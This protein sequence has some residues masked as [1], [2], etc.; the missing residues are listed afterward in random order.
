MTP[1]MRHAVGIILLSLSSMGTYTCRFGPTP[2]QGTV[3]L[4]VPFH[5]QKFDAISSQPERN[6]CVP[7]SI[8]MV[9]DYYHGGFTPNSV[10]H[11]I[12]NDAVARGWAALGQPPFGGFNVGHVGAAFTLYS[13]YAHTNRVYSDRGQALADAEKNIAQGNPVPAIVHGDAHIVVIRGVVWSADAST[14]NRPRQGGV[15]VHD[16][17]VGPDITLENVVPISTW[18]GFWG[19]GCS[20]TCAINISRFGTGIAAAEYA[21][22][23][24]AAG[25][26][27]GEA[28]PPVLSP[29]AASISRPEHP[30]S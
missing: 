17:M 12:W 30:V 24:E 28:A 19:S 15:Y 22:F 5:H 3:G 26:Y 27:L 18:L 14:S 25:T 7:A 23:E 29:H 1:K 8:L 20:G 21:E 6:Y 4:S 16:P 9:K 11:S 10:Q 13:G 2:P